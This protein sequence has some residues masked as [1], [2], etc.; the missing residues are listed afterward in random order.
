MSAV[1]NGMSRRW[2]WILL[3]AALAVSTAAPGGE[4]AEGVRIATAPCSTS[5]RIT[6]CLAS[7]PGRGARAS[8]RRDLM[9]KTGWTALVAELLRDGG[10]R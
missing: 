9:N 3:S 5:P 10:A 8:S 6:A 2:L 1:D 4:M 7:R